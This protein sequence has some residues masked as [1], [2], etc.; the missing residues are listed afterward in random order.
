ML[1]D[2][3]NVL[4]APAAFEVLKQHEAA[5]DVFTD[6]SQDWPARLAALNKISAALLERAPSALRHSISLPLLD[7]E[8]HLTL[9]AAWVQR[10][11]QLRAGNYKGLNGVACRVLLGARGIGKTNVMLALSYA[12]STV[13]PDIIPL[14]V[15]G[16][17]L[18]EDSSFRKMDL[19]DLMIATVRAHGVAVDESKGA[20]AL[21]DALEKAGKRMLVVVDEVE[22]LYCVDSS[23]TNM[24][25]HAIDTLRFLQGLGN[26]KSGR[27]AVLLCS[28]SA[29]TYSLLFRGINEHMLSRFPVLRSSPDLNSSKFEPLPIPAARCTATAQVERILAALGCLPAEER[30]LEELQP[31][32]GGGHPAMPP[33]KSLQLARLLTFFVG[34]TPRAITSALQPTKDGVLPAERLQQLVTAQLMFRLGASTMTAHARELFVELL[35][36]L[37]DS[38][39]EV[40]D[41]LRAS[42]GSANTAAVM[43]ESW[44]GMVKPLEWKHVNHAWSELAKSKELPDSDSASYV[45]TLVNILSEES[46]VSLRLD[47]GTSGYCL[48]PASAA[49]LIYSYP[50]TPA[51]ELLKGAARE[52]QPLMRGAR[53]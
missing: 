11:E 2:F 3:N 38:N 48:W 53:R 15:T 34:T 6:S 47:P 9:L 22:Q 49:Q 50:N 36:L 12:C 1:G 24:R 5:V 51:V 10:A 8:S 17:V 43:M 42:D 28:S 14:W 7:T 23:E 37:Q 25:Q 26:Q 13:F 39:K 4:T 18:D 35:K 52:L 29:F 40:R 16:A 20:F 30:K 21:T 44:E 41:L 19:E 46:L 27:Y 45:T 33:R 32:G 31:T